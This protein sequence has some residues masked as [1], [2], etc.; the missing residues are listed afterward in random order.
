MSMG[1]ISA[2]HARTVLENVERVLALELLCAAQ[3]LDFRLELVPGAAPG[4]GVAAAHARLRSVVAH[5]DRGPRARARHRGRD[6][7]RPERRAG[8]LAEACAMSAIHAR[9]P[10][11]PPTLWP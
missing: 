3:A 5:L 7:P 1:S 4:A 8:G 11:R 6:R 10:G 2:R 9:P